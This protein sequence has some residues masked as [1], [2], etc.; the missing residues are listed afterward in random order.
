LSTFYTP[1]FRVLWC[2]TEALLKS[3]GRWLIVAAFASGIAL[4][5]NAAAIPG[6]ALYQ[7]AAD[8]PPKAW[9]NQVTISG[10][11][12][13]V[14]DGDTIRV[15]HEPALRWRRTPGKRAKLSET[16][17]AVR[18]MGIDAPETAKFGAKGQPFSAEATAFV[19]EEVLGKRVTVK[20]LR[21]DQVLL[22]TTNLYFTQYKQFLLSCY[23]LRIRA[24]KHCV[25]FIDSIP[26]TLMYLLLS[27]SI[28][29]VRNYSIC[30]L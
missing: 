1:L 11:V 22:F 3:V 16:T 18:L 12:A 30:E 29:T 19:K 21:K 14:T 15:R 7:T 8:I 4:G 27:Y 13:S 10:I 23:P 9:E 26:Y 28:Y 24:C 2:S 5:A 25:A 17:I 20:L 6:F